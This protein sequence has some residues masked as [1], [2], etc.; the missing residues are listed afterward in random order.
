MNLF[1]E[2]NRYS[3]SCQYSYLAA[4]VKR[5]C[6]PLLCLGLK[7]KRTVLRKKLTRGL[8]SSDVV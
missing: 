7:F 3:F 8:Y 2:N 6:E 4:P 5:I 1:L